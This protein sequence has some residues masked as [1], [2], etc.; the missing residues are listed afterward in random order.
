MA[1]KKTSAK[2]SAS[3]TSKK[4]TSPARRTTGRT[5]SSVTAPSHSVDV[6]PVETRESYR[7]PII[8]RSV[9]IAVIAAII[10]IGLLYYAKGFFVAA[11]VN[12]QPI[13]RWSV[14]HSLEQQGGKQ[15]LDSLVTDTVIQQE[16]SKR[17]I[18]ASQSDIN[19]QIKTISDN[20]SK[21]GQ[22]L[23]SALA[24]QGMTKQDLNDRIKIQVLVQK[25]VAPVKVT[26]AEAKD[27]MNKNKDSNP[28]GSSLSSVKD[29]L[30]QQ[31]LQAE[32]QTFVTNLRSKAKVTT[33]VNY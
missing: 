10:V 15:A 7:R 24:A 2:K 16:A 31:K 14:I 28:P 5:S 20:L 4:R 1:T 21:Q 13:S 17:H 25:M 9:V 30:Q 22:T 12:G 19:S 33:W 18:T 27:Y 26:D 8:R 3:S 23:D 6:L 32:E 11:L 29:Q